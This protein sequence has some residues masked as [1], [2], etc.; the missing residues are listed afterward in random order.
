MYEPQNGVT[1][2]SPGEDSPGRGNAP[3]CN[4]CFME[5]VIVPAFVDALHIHGMDEG[6]K[7]FG[8]YLYGDL[9]DGNFI[10]HTDGAN[11]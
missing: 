2:G 4:Y 6:H 9:N 5:K 11:H 3:R 10:R 8:K 1:E 7:I